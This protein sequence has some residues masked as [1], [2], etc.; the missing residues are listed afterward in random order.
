[1]VPPRQRARGRNPRQFLDS[2]RTIKAKTRGRISA[3]ARRAVTTESVDPKVTLNVLTAVKRGD[4]SARMP[5]NWTG[6]AARVAAALNESIESNQ[7]LE[8]EL[9]R[10]SKRVGKEGQM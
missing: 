7:R 9:H 5:A 8:R 1:M 2:I 3:L 10:L 6:P 4:F